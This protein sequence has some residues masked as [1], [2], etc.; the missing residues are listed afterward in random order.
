MIFWKYPI[1]DFFIHESIV[2]NLLNLTLWGGFKRF[3]YESVITLSWLLIS[4]LFFLH[5]ALWLVKRMTDI[6]KLSH[7][8]S[9]IS[10]VDFS[11]YYRVTS[12]LWYESLWLFWT[13]Y[14]HYVFTKNKNVSY[15]TLRGKKIHN[16]LLNKF[17]P[18]SSKITELD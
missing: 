14:I 9:Y 13:Q 18:N 16:K 4:Q 2:M 6:F 8:L 12:N 3:C 10:A 7:F 17:L 11:F 5:V 15:N 1:V